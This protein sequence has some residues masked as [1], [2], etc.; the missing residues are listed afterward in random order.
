MLRCITIA[1]L[2]S[3]VGFVA[4]QAMEIYELVSDDVQ[5]YTSCG[6]FNTTVQ[7]VNYVEW[8]WKVGPCLLYRIAVIIVIV[9]FHRIY[10]FSV[11][12]QDE[13]TCHRNINTF[14]LS[15]FLSC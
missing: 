15:L 10:D 4:L 7:P 5:K 6:T 9:L 8:Y 12:R 1:L 14:L 13:G 3:G 2:I 11:T